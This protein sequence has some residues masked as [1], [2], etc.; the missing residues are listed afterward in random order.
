MKNKNIS[1]CFEKNT[2]IIIANN[3]HL[4]AI[5]RLKEIDYDNDGDKDFIAAT[6]LV[7][8]IFENNNG[9]FYK[10]PIIFY[11]E[12]DIFFE[13][14]A[15]E[16]LDLNDDGLED[17]IIGDYKGNLKVYLNNNNLN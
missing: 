11:N 5:S 13:Y 10:N 6:N 4:L 2:G 8:Y 17:I 15:L 14:I 16:V 1:T 9:I 7:I 12:N 3:Y